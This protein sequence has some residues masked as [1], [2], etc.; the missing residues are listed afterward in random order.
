MFLGM[1]R[2]FVGPLQMTHMQQRGM[3]QLLWADAVYI[4]DLTTLSSLPPV[5]QMML[6]TL[7]HELFGSADVAAH[8]VYHLAQ[9]NPDLDARTYMRRVMK[10]MLTKPSL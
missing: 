9:H 5:R 4:R 10:E 2:R 3:N 6:A 7:V 8:I 1:A